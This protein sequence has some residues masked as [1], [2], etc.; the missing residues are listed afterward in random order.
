MTS[1]SIRNKLKRKPN[2][3]S[4]NHGAVMCAVLGQLRELNM[5]KMDRDQKV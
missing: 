1:C 5:S 3:A 4:R 2:D